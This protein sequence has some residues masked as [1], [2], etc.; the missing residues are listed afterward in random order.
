MLGSIIKSFFGCE[1]KV[2]SRPLTGK[3]RT[4]KVKVE[5]YPPYCLPMKTLL[6]KGKPYTLVEIEESLGKARGT[7]YHEMSELRKSG[8]V[9]TKKYD[10]AISAYRY[11]NPS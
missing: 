4:K 2:T 5:G 1:E 11:R 9:I 10:K 8:F 3:S 7:V 6:E